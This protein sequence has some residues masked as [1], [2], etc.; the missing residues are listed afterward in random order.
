MLTEP[1]V[2]EELAPEG[3]QQTLGAVSRCHQVAAVALPSGQFGNVLELGHDVSESK[4]R[5]RGRRGKGGGHRPAG[6]FPEVGQAQITDV[7]DDGA[8]DAAI[9][10]RPDQDGASTH[11]RDA[12]PPG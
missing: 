3:R 10:A 11:A 12:T 8:A 6:V 2:L 1:D 9:G 5:L 4:W 7:A